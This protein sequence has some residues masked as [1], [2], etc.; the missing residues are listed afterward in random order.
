MDVQE[1]R[2]S[3]RKGV[4]IF[5]KFCQEKSHH[6]NYLFCFFEGEDKK[7][8]DSRIQKYTSYEYTKI[9]SF[10]CGGR[11]EVLKVH[12]L[13]TKE[14]IYQSVKKA[15]FIDRDYEPIEINY[16]DIYQTP[17]YSIE[18]LYTSLSAFRKLIS[19]EFCINAIEQDF[20][21]CMLDYEKAQK[22]FHKETLL[23]NAWIFCQREVERIEQKQLICL[24]DFKVAHL[25]K[26][27]N[28]DNII[29]NNEINLNEINKLF[30]DSYPLNQDRLSE[31]I[32]LFQS[33]NMQ[34]VFRGKFEIEFLKNIIEDLKRKNKKQLY[35]IIHRDC[36][37]VDV[38]VNPLSSLSEY[39]D[40]PSCL[41]SFLSRYN[42][43]SIL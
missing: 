20:E 17:C 15:F 43:S 4:V 34:Q 14:E 42:E 9:I 22:N 23:L 28:I 8:Y 29:C 38:N 36:V 6:D 3:R 41:I 32:S 26:T 11:K 31:V 39:A 25:F 13:I 7:Y 19:R 21:K 24:K 5:T 2:A 27:I 33:Q 12:D 40:T 30:E 1:I 16:N 10:N 37:R 35:F 18:N